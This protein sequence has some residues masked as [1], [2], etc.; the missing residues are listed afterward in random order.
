MD[1]GQ[2]ERNTKVLQTKI[3]QNIN[4]AKKDIEDVIVRSIT[5]N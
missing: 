5:K 3:A 2:N 4:V 1:T